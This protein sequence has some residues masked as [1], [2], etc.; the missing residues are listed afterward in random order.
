[1]KYT[2]LGIALHKKCNASC[3]TCCF[4]CN[5]NC[6][7]RLDVD[8]IKRFIRSTENDL[9]LSVISFTGGE[10]FLEYDILKEL[11]SYTTKKGKIASCITN[12]FWANNTK[13]T[14]D[15]L[16]ELRILGLKQLSVSYDN[17]HKEFVSI[18]NIR[19]ILNATQQLNIETS[20]GMVKNKD[21]SIND[22]I[23][24]L[25]DYIININIRISPCIPVGNA[26]RLFNNMNFIRN[27]KVKN[28]Y[29]PYNGYMFMSFDGNIYPCCSHYV[30][31]TGLSIGNYKIINFQDSINL[32]KKNGLLYI[33]RNYGF[34]FFIDIANKLHINIP[35]TVVQPCEL[36]SVLFSEDNINKFYPYIKKK[37]EAIINK[38]K[39]DI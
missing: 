18:Q 9:N 36:C 12:G 28:L 26:K 33:L 17:Y 2:T 24:E 29:C 38:R 14:Y 34:D 39:G 6:E 25:G 22:L 16:S 27:T 11:V 8:L 37:I 5:P 23:S 1:M 3:K 10:P 31:A 35:N 30:T 15:I 21:E 4:S 32:I 20:L 7:E 19:N 13:D